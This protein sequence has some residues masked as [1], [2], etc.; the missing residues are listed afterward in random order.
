MGLYAEAFES[1]LMGLKEEEM[2]SELTPDQAYG[3]FNADS[4]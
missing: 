3:S 1:Q 2:T 4:C